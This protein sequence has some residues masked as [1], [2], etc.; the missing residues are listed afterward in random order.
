MIQLH[1]APQILQ[2]RRELRLFPVPQHQN[3]RSPHPPTSFS[4][5][6]T[7]SR[8]VAAS[9]EARSAA[10]KPLAVISRLRRARMRRCPASSVEQV[11]KKTYV[12]TQWISTKGLLVRVS[13]EDTR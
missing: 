11:R 3:V 7:Q 8:A 6:A 1:R 4:N 9:G 13:S 12:N 2:S 5:F 10:R